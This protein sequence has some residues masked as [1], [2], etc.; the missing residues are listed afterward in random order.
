VSDDDRQ[1]DAAVS[2]ERYICAGPQAAD[3]GCRL[4]RGELLY[5]DPVTGASYCARCA[6]VR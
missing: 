4:D 3:C 2:L 6:P 1:A 5:V